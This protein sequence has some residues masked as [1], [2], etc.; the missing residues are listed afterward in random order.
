MTPPI[1]AP[2]RA[3]RR[4]NRDVPRK[5]GP[6]LTLRR[7][8]E[9]LRASGRYTFTRAEATSAL[10]LSSAALKNAAWRLSRKGRLVSPH[11]GFYVVVP[12]EYQASGTVPPSWIIRDL[13]VTLKRQYYVGLL[14]GASLHGAAHQ[15][16]QEFQ[17]VSD[18]PTRPMLLG[19]TRIFFVTKARLAKTPTVAV[20]TPT[21]EIRVSTPEA[22]ALDLVTYPEQA[23]SL[24]NV[25]TVLAEL[26]E[27]MTPEALVRAAEAEGEIASAQRVGYLLERV[28]HSDLVAPLARWIDTRKPRV[29]PLRPGRRMGGRPRAARWRVAINEKLEID[30]PQ[31]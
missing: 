3:K 19:R 11:R 30:T 25:A 2:K 1:R 26:A 18:K 27:R 10:H 15:A 23:G 6:R 29:V 16:P 14:S 12:P 17:V 20:K 5:R 31:A 7:F 21:G 28:G 13:M 8:L 22:T 4:I 24:S 9:E